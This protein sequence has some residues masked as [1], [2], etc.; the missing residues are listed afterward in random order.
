MSPFSP[1]TRIP[2]AVLG[3]TG[4]VGQSFIRFMEDGRVMP[5]TGGL[6]PAQCQL[7]R[8]LAKQQVAQL[9]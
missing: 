7:I 1:K 5:A 6:R 2:V 3:A 8:D 4:A 9:K